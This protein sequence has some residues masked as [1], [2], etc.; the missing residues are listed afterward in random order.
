MAKYKVGAAETWSQIAQKFNLTVPQLM[1]ANKGVSTLSTGMGI[2]VP[3]YSQPIGPQRIGVTSSVGGLN[4]AQSN[5]RSGPYDNNLTGYYN[6]AYSKP[7]TTAYPSVLA[8]EQG[9]GLPAP[10]VTGRGTGNY[11]MNYRQPTTPTTTGNIYN[12]PYSS[13]M[14]E[15][16]PVTGQPRYNYVQVR[17]QNGRP[18]TNRDGTP[19]TAPMSIY[20]NDVM[21]EARFSGQSV[22]Q[23]TEQLKQNGYVLFGGKWVYVGS[24]QPQPQDQRPGRL[25]NGNL[26]RRR[27]VDEQVVAVQQDGTTENTI[28]TS[29]SSFNVG[30]G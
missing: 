18:M 27:R 7:P 12:N 2:R 13:I 4:A 24:G 20:A 6:D 25:R 22:A 1:G 19:V 21:T 10:T 5:A 16:D 29:S 3:Q 26:A 15:R 23:F 9:M 14:Y 17:D 8:K 30:S 28:G 11:N